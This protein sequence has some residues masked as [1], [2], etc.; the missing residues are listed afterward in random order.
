MKRFK[1]IVVLL[2]FLASCGDKEKTNQ[3]KLEGTWI[4]YI[5]DEEFNRYSD[6]FVITS[7]TI[8]HY[9]KNIKN[10][11]NDYRVSG[12]VIQY[13]NGTEIDSLF[14][15]TFKSD[16]S[17]ILDPSKYQIVIGLDPKYYLTKK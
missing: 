11:Y 16:N 12:N 15:L 4:G 1:I 17:L 13:Q 14:D 9:R 3:E 6:T 10:I 8:F 5:G 7:N 2:V